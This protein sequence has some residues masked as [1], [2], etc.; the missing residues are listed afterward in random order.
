MC[1]R[2]AV[3]FTQV[4]IPIYVGVSLNMDKTAVA[5][6]PLIVF[7]SSLLIA[8]LQNLLTKK[9]GLALLYIIG[10]AIVT[11]SCALVYVIQEEYCRWIY[12]TA[13]LFGIG[14]TVVSI[15]SVS[16]E[17]DLVSKECKTSAFVYG[18]MSLTDK[19]SNGIAILAVQLHRKVLS[20]PD[21]DI[22]TPADSRFVR[23]I[24]T[25]VPVISCLIACIFTLDVTNYSKKKATAKS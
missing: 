10:S 22:P 1:T 9:L 8:P 16:Y 3:N 20:G 2:L 21:P 24:L 12:A 17:A 19:L 25:L 5:T 7:L 13:F 18:I 11:G 6:V 4:Y 15:V 23:D 14:T